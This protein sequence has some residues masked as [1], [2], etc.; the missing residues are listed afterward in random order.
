MISVQNASLRRRAAAR[1][2][3]MPSRRALFSAGLGILLAVITGELLVRNLARAWNY[4]PSRIREVRNYNEGIATYHFEADGIGPFGNRLTGLPPIPDGEVGVIV[5][6]S[7]VLAESVADVD[8]MGAE[9]ERLGRQ[10]GIRLNVRQYGWYAGAA[11]DYVANAPEIL[12]RWQPKWVV[13][14]MNWTDFGAE[15]LEESF[16]WRM[17]IQPDLSIR[18]VD[19][20]PTPNGRRERLKVLLSRS[21]LL[22]ALYRRFGL[23]RAATEPASAASVETRPVVDSALITRASI[24][25]LHNSYGEKLLIVYLGLTVWDDK[26]DPAE[27]ELMAD[28]LKEKVDCVSTSPLMRD[29]LRERHQLSRGFP[30]TSPGI[31]HLNEIGHA[32]TGE[33]IWQALVRRTRR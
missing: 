27:D 4:P 18:L 7:H 17:T 10:A 21:S 29:V 9:V 19:V 33:V 15:P 11:P 13:A 16:D 24:R 25:A 14:A 1:L 26:P 8:T 22:T 2:W 6:D 20:R 3:P 30:T 12:S 28:C 31:G 32:I 23:F 5:G